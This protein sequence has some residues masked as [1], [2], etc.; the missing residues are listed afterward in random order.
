MGSFQDDYRVLSSVKSSPDDELNQDYLDED[1]WMPTFTR[2]DTESILYDQPVG[3]AILRASSSVSARL[4]LSYK[5]ENSSIS[6]F[7]IEVV[8][9]YY[10][11]PQSTPTVQNIS[12]IS[13]NDIL[14]YYQLKKYSKKNKHLNF[15]EERYGGLSL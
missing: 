1:F 9:T 5:D 7:L 15:A 6:H 3:T 10:L 2:A 11:I 4:V 13:I 8:S 12:F 14:S